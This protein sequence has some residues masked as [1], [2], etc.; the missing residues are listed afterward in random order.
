MGINIMPTD[1]QVA[2]ILFGETHALGHNSLSTVIHD[3]YFFCQLQAVAIVLAIA[4]PVAT[5]RGL[6]Q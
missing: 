6:L 3:C 5:N 4:K 1:I 2:N